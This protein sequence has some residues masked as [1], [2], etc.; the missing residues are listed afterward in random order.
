MKTKLTENLCRNATKRPADQHNQENVNV[1]VQLDDD[2]II[3]PTV[4]A[5]QRASERS[6]STTGRKLFRDV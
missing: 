3:W 5:N 1:V 6:D 4:F 2:E